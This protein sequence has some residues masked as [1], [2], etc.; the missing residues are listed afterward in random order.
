MKIT[1]NTKLSEILTKYPGIMGELT[2]ISE[3]FKLINS[4]IGK[5]MV[6]KATV[7]EMSGKAGMAIED[8]V[9]ALE[10]LVKEQEHK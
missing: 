8:L 6:K 9:A 3:R 5:V 1:A 7:K 4:P 2:R 10:A